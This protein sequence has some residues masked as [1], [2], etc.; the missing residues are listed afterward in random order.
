M[1]LSILITQETDKRLSE[2]ERYKQSAIDLAN[3]LRSLWF[4]WNISTARLW[5]LWNESITQTQGTT[6]VNI[7]NNNNVAS[8]VDVRAV[9]RQTAKDVARATATWNTL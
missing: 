4:E 2:I 3:T 6:V 5:T 7:T 1:D 8:S 9:A